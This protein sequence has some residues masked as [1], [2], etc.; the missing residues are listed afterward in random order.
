MAAQ[1]H[2]AFTAGQLEV[3]SR[4]LLSAISH[5]RPGAAACDR[6]GM[7]ARATEWR[8]EERQYWEIMPLVTQRIG[9]S[10]ARSARIGQQ[11]EAG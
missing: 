6:N 10:Q 4:A 2:D 8:A 3:I 5:T 7:T 11:S 9:V 1:G